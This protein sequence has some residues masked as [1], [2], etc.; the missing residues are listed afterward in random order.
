MRVAMYYSVQDIRIEE[1][2][3]PSIGPGELL[4]R[5]RASGICGSD[6]MEW[7]RA[8]SAP[9]VLGHEIAGE[10]AAV[11]EGVARFH[12]GDR[13]F[14]THHVPCG[15]CRYCQQGHGSVCETLRRT[16]FHPG[17]FA[18]YVRVPQINVE[19]GTLPLPEELSF[20]E[21]SFIEP[22]ACVV[23]GQRMARLQPGQTVLVIGS[24]TAGL[25]HVQ[26]ARARGA[27][28]V[29]ASD[30]NESRL[31][32]ARRLGADATLPAADLPDGL[33]RVNDQRLAD[34][35]VVCTGALPA[36]RQ[37]VRSVDRGGTVL[38]FAPAPEGVEVP[39]PL[40]E[41]WR[42]EVT[43]ATSY[44]AGPQDL[45]EAIELLRAGS[46][47]V[48]EMITHRLSL[49]EAGRGFEL[50]ASGQDAI[51]VIID[52]SRKNGPGLG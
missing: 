9:L 35:V 16:H 14:V 25:L 19:L 12:V 27:G 48:E 7:Y 26:L 24:G 23:R 31:R 4:V 41:L 47:R 43:V 13:V 3:V 36:I 18:E 21:G 8:R 32:A 52:P 6:V 33:Y 28:R 37:A 17:G 10:V 15:Q 51:K 29:I 20:D 5:V 39:I 2:P 45:A 40:F 22:L 46:V 38:F 50:V 44:A 11:G 49:A 34:V 42:D 30:I 1:M